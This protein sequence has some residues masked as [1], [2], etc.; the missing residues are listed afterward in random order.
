MLFNAIFSYN[1]Q[2]S[3]HYSGIS[4]N[5]TRV[6]YDSERNSVSLRVNNSNKELTWLLRSW[7]SNY[8]DNEIN[9][10]F[11]LTPP[12]YRLSP[13]ENLQLRI[14]NIKPLPKD[15]ESVFRINVLAIPPKSNIKT[16]DNKSSNGM[17]FA[18]NN[19]IKLF[20]R[21]NELNI[22]EKVKSAYK[23][24]KVQKQRDLLDLHNPTP[25]YIS[26]DN[27]RINGKAVSGINDFMIAPFSSLTIP[28]KNVKS[29][30]Y[31]TINDYG[32][33]TPKTDITF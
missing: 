25:Y 24:I 8:S 27:V 7:V 29:L 5:A 19:R 14:E 2:A 18:I 28:V 15:R 30:S 33:N 31:N 6:I 4:L 11:I 13:Q 17:Q 32:G 3:D 23:E 22:P 10:S 21:P 12:L 9:N 20:Y 1:S 26:L 16:T